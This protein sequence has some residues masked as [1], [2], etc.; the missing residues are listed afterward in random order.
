MT[1]G[2]IDVGYRL[3]SHAVSAPVYA[4][5]GAVGADLF[6][7]PPEDQPIHLA[8]GARAAAPTGLILELP[9][10]WEAQVRPRSG[11]AR[12][13]GVTTLNAPGTIDWDYR[14]EIEVLLINHGDQP[15]EIRRGMRVAQLV[16]APAHRARWEERSELSGTSRGAAGFGSTGLGA[17]VARE[18]G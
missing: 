15:V 11:L 5:E 13:H 6:A 3:L 14:G 4:T 1:A 17:T 10:G 7:A 9:P 2:E 8:P 16:I 18:G 12:R